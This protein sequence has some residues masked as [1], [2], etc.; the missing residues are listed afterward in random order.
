MQPSLA[1]RFGSTT[2]ACCLFA[3]A[4]PT[5]A[6]AENPDPTAKIAARVDAYL[7]PLV[8]SG[9]F[10]GA[11]LVARNGRILVQSAYGAAHVASHVDNT[12]QTRF[13]LMSVSKTLTAVALMTLVE[14]GELELEDPA[15]KYLAKWPA[16]WHAVTLRHLLSHTSGI[17]NLE[18]DW[19][20]LMPEAE[21]RDI[22]RWPRLA[23]GLGERSLVFPPG[24]RTSYS[25]F[26]FI[27]LGLVIEAVSGHAYGDY[28]QSAV[29]DPAGMENTGIDD[30]G[31]FEGLAMGYFRGNGGKLDESE[32]N[33]SMIRAAGGFFSS[34]GDLYRFDRALHRNDLL[35][36][37]T[38]QLMWTPVT[39]A[40]A[41]GWQISRWHDRRL[42]HHSGGSNGFVA[43]FLRLPDDDACIVV[44][45]NFAFAPIKQISRDL[46]AILFGEPHATPHPLSA[47]RL[48]AFA[49]LYRAPN[50]PH[51]SLLIRPSGS[52]L[53]LFDIG[54]RSDRIGGRLLFPS[55][56]DRF[57]M[58]RSAGQLQFVRGDQGSGFDLY[59]QQGANET[60]MERVTVPRQSWRRTLGTYSIQP[61]PSP[62]VELLETGEQLRLRGE[63]GWPDVE[64]VP[65][66]ES[67]AVGLWR[68]TLGTVLRLTGDGG[69]ATDA[70][71]A[72]GGAP[73]AFEWLRIDNVKMYGVRTGAGR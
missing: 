59:L 45:S 32:Q 27:L 44:L 67:Q 28:L 24:E 35:S 18:L 48:T 57:M 42:I 1:Q 13:K 4:W 3:A 66:S 20:R 22:D 16:A 72:S 8:D 54:T 52:A 11:V 73:Q 37:E 9:L 14:K 47:S 65:L 25:N 33:M 29:L 61:A 39:Q 46:A 49:G 2:V 63:G 31:R 55:G 38:R 19:S 50:H 68:E 71:T 23:A 41:H 56:P 70:A 64:L 34:V 26:N 53:L 69:T 6:C 40:F 60:V 36:A 21:G 12:P 43:D 15:A 10:S 51:R 7:T 30:G 17:P 5:A 62:P 58:P